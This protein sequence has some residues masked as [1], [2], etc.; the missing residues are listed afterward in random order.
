MAQTAP[1]RTLRLWSLSAWNAVP[2]PMG[3]HGKGPGAKYAITRNRAIIVP[4]VPTPTAKHPT[5]KRAIIPPNAPK[6]PAHVA[7]GQ[8]KYSPNQL[9]SIGLNSLASPAGQVTGQDTGQVPPPVTLS[10]PPPVTLPVALP[11][12]VAN[13]L[14]LL[15]SKGTLGNSDLLKVF[16]LKDRTHLREH[17]I[18]PALGGGLVERTIP[19]KPTSRL[20]KYRLTAKGRALLDSQAPNA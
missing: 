17:Y 18:D 10:V 2:Q 11:V 9:V 14:R 7:T 4:N 3:H 16:G 20:Q 1:E 13:L 12:A 19:D 8:V 15:D 6:L 5:G